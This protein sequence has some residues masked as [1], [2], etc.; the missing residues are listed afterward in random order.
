[1]RDRI[2]EVAMQLLAA[3]G[4]EGLSTRSVA[5]AAGTQVPTLYRLFGDKAG[6]LAAV[7]EQGY[8]AYLAAKPRPGAEDDAVAELRAGWDPHVEFGLS[9]P[10]LFAVM[11]A[12]PQPDRPSTTAAAALRILAARVHAIAGS[13]RLRV[14]EQLATGMIHAAATGVVMTLLAAPAD[15]RGP[16]LSAAA[17]DAVIAAVT[18]DAPSDSAAGPGSAATTLRAQLPDLTVLTEGERHVLDEWLA[19]IVDR[20]G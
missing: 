20:T 5:A 16:A 10:A 18:T 14:G 2:V 9:N 6:L 8:A 17:F 11:Y 4:R 1:M 12:D 19:R 15:R 7:A 13:G 3:R